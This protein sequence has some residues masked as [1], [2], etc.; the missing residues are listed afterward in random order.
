MWS[1]AMLS[2]ISQF[3]ILTLTD[4]SLKNDKKL[5]DKRLFEI[6]TCPCYNHFG[7]NTFR[8]SSMVERRPVNLRQLTM[9]TL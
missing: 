4:Q 2:T 3:H 7:C 9:E 1:Y 5:I 8:D 6:L